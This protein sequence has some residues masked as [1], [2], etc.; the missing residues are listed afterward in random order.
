MTKYNPVK[1]AKNLL[2]LGV[3]TG[4][5]YGALGALGSIAPK[6]AG[7]ALNTIGS[8]LQ[9]GA[10]GGL[11]HAGLGLAG[12]LGGGKNKHKHIE[13]KVVKGLLHKHKW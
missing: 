6:E 1:N 13:H 11:A 2:K 10:I 9:L 8:G 7:P 4:A 12:S 5:G 3:V